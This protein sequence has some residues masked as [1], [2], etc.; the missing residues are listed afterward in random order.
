M[1][2]LQ[3]VVIIL[4]AQEKSDVDSNLPLTVGWDARTLCSSFAHENMLSPLFK[5]LFPDSSFAVLRPASAQPTCPRALFPISLQE[6]YFFF[7][8]LNQ[9]LRLLSN[10]EFG[11]SFLWALEVKNIL[12][13]IDCPT[14]I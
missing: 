14:E 8:F 4:V 1:H 10:F 5:K 6:Y 11:A 2:T 3:L 9:A 12:K 13:F 7:F